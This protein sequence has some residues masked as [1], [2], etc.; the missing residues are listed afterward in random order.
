MNEEAGR[1]KWRWKERV[2]NREGE[3]KER[4]NEEIRKR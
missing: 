3:L 4:R 2:R 1:R